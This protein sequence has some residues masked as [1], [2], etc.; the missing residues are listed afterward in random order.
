V[1][2]HRGVAAEGI[3]VSAGSCRLHG[4][5]WGSPSARLVIGFPGLTGNAEHFAFLGER[6]GGDRCQLVALDPRGRGR[7]ETPSLGSYGWENHARDVLA[8]GD[9]LGFDR[10]AIVGQSMGGSVAMKVA[11]LDGERLDAVVLVDVAGRVD[12]G[13]GAVIAAAIN[14]QGGTYDSV[15]RY[16]DAVKAERLI[17]PWSSYWDRAYGDDL[18]DVGGRVTSRTSPEAVAEDRAYTATQHP[19]DRWKHLTMPTLLLRATRE[20]RPGSGFIVP[21][22]DRERF[23][24]EVPGATVIDIDAN[25]LTINTHMAAAIAI[26]DFLTRL[27]AT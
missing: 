20:L 10:F 8:V 25:H 11:E 21:A 13:V 4:R 17:E 7:S 1:N 15:E 26:D 22:V 2:R 23:E 9:A 18:M 5:R 6:I 3:D 19:Y 14:R 16:L 12:P 27:V 24:R